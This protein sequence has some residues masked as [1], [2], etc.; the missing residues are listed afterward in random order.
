ME[1]MQSFNRKLIAGLAE[2][3][4]ETKSISQRMSLLSELN[5]DDLLILRN[6]LSQPQ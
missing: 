4:Q 2:A 5:L 3:Q 6:D 1:N